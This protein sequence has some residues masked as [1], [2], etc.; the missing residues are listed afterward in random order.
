MTSI[1]HIITGLNVGGAERALYTLLTN[2]LEG[3]FCNRVI[4]LM[5]PGHYGPLLRE[6]EVPVTCLDMNPGKPTIGAFRRLLAAVSEEPADILQGWMLHG[7]LAAMLAWRCGDR[8]ASLLWNQRTSLDTLKDESWMKRGLVRLE[9]ALSGAPHAIIY[10]SARSRTQFAVHGYKG[11]R[12]VHLPNGFDTEMWF[13]C[14][15]TRKKVRNSLAIPQD[16]I[17]IGYVGRGHLEKDPELLFRAFRTISKTHKNAWLL[18][19]GRDLDRFNPPD[20]NTLLLGQRADVQD[21]MRAMDL[22]CLSSRTEGFPN[23]IGEAMAT[24]VPCVAT[25]VGD[26]RE[27][28]GNTGWVSPARDL[29]GLVASLHAALSCAPIT[30]RERGIAARD[31]IANHYSVSSVVER[32]SALYR[33]VLKESV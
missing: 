31:R 10:N 7:N 13:P 22:F 26:A 9:A 3:E 32:Y 6:A 1:T 33:S 28:V 16:A 5:G 4:S 23:V 11:D 18:A 29:Q 15:D 20:H 25:D 8:D 2:G 21:L 14:E 24:G 12:A 27:I 30:L 17:V 19:V